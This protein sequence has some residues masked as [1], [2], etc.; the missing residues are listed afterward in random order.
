MTPFSQ[1][2]PDLK[3]GANRPAILIGECKG[4]VIEGREPPP[5]KQE[6]KTERK[7]THRSTIGDAS[8][9]PYL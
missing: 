3:G 4:K 9:F 7:F 5:V 1:K 8:M 6:N 2:R